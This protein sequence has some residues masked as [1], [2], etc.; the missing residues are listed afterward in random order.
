MT[1]KR[2]TPAHC[3]P[4]MDLLGEFTVQDIRRQA[5]MARDPHRRRVLAEFSNVKAERRWREALEREG[6]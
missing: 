3:I 2:I 4:V 6:T 1:R 5:V